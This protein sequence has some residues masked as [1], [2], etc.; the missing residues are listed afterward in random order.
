MPDME[1]SV[2]RDDSGVIRVEF[3]SDGRRPPLLGP[4][5]FEALSSLADEAMT[6]PPE[7]II[8]S[9]SEDGDFSAGIDLDDMAEVGSKGEA[10]EATRVIQLLYQRIADL[11]C[12]VVAAIEGRCIGGGTEL[13]LACDARIAADTPATSLLLP[14]ILLGIIPGLGG[15]QR[16]PR[17][18]GQQQALNMIL[19]S[20]P[21]P[22]RMA[23][24]QGLIDRLVEPGQLLEEAHR[25]ILDLKEGRP[26]RLS[27]LPRRNLTDWML[28][29]TRRGRRMVR[30]RYLRVV[31]RRTGGNLPAPEVAIRAVGLAADGL[32][33]PEG[34][35]READMVAGLMAG[36]IHPHLLRLLRC[37]Q[38]MRR[39]RGATSGGETPLDLTAALILPDELKHSL[40]NLFR[41]IPGMDLSSPA[42]PV[43]SISTPGG[44]G[45][46]RRLP[47]TVPPAT[48]EVTW[49]GSEPSDGPALDLF[50]DISRRLVSEAGGNPVY[51]RESD[52]S[53]GL[54][55]LQVYL[56][57]GERLAAEGWEREGIDEILEEWGMAR[58]PIALAGQ[59][60][61]AWDPDPIPP[62]H[63]RD[64]AGSGPSG[65][66]ASE[67][68]IDEVVAALSLEIGRRWQAVDEPVEEGWLILDVF[69]LGGPAFR[70]GI[71]GAARHLGP[72]HLRAVLLDLEERYGD[73]YAADYPVDSGLFLQ[74]PGA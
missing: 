52:P 40:G 68:L 54:S 42:L 9:G 45:L 47:L 1:P 44:Y 19:T 32:P 70:G 55:L 53:P 49:I 8:I 62:L 73:R 3:L 25:T 37:R 72:D 51:C 74:Y 12:P 56:A 33:L 65:P 46:L 69:V 17:L 34:L 23:F 10:F 13:V 16:L 2:I 30:E 31:R 4:E 26:A 41:S 11:P 63:D 71:I 38:A 43:P 36:D 5:V 28:E 60:G 21:V 66:E 61:E 27:R 7:G 35:E 48:I 57:E 6:D 59:L 24:E 67:R 29:R 15:S 20:R 14:E 58:G 50:Q 39:P 18:I 64:P 22:A